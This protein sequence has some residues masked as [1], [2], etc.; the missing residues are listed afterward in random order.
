M[1]AFRDMQDVPSPTQAGMKAR[2]ELDNHADTSCG[3]ANCVPLY[4]TGQVCEVSGFSQDIGKLDNIP[5]ATVCTVWTSPKTGLSYLLILPQVL[6]FGTKLESSLINPNQLRHFGIRV[7]DDP[8]DSARPFGIDME[9]FDEADSILPFL[10]DGTT[11]YFDTRVPTEQE[12]L[13]L[14]RIQLTRD[15]PWDP[16][17]VSIASLSLEEEEL[18]R[19]SSLFTTADNDD[20]F[21]FQNS[22]GVTEMEAD[23]VLSQISPVYSEKQFTE[24]LLG[25]VKVGMGDRIDPE[26][27]KRRVN[28]RMMGS[29]TRHSKVTPEELA[30]KWGVG[31]DTARQTLQATTQYGVRK[32]V[33]PLTRRYR[34]D[35]LD[36]HRRRLN[37]RFYADTL[38]SRNQSG[39]QNTCAQVYTNGKFSLVC[40]MG[41]RSE[42]G[43]TLATFFDEVGVFENL[44]HD[45]APEM[46]GKN[47]EFYKLIQKNRVSVHVT[48]PGRHSQNHVAEK[49]IGE[50]KRRWKSIMTTK[51]VP[52]RIWDYALVWNSEIMSRT[53]RGPDKRTGY[54]EVFG[55]T[56]DISEWLDFDFYDKVF[57]W[58]KEHSD[59]TDENRKIGRWLGIA[60]RIGSDLCYWVL[61]Q[62][63][64]VIARTTV[65]HILREELLKP[66]IKERDEIF[67]EEVRRRLDD[68]D[69]VIGEP[70]TDAF[71]LEDYDIEEERQDGPNTPTDEE[72]GD[73]L[74]EPRPEDDD[75]VLDAYIGAEVNMEQPDGEVIRGRVK[76]RARDD[77]GRPIGRPHR[78]PF[79]DSSM[80]EVELSDG[81]TADYMANVIAENM[82]SQVDEEGRQYLLLKEIVDHRKTEEALTK[83]QVSPTNRTTTKGWDFLVEWKDG[84]TDWVPHK[85]LKAANPIELAE[86]V[87]ANRIN[88]EPAFAWWVPHVLRKRERILKKAKSRYWRTDYKFGIKLPHSVEEALEIDRETGTTFWRNGIEKE[89][90]KVKPAFEITDLDVEKVRR[91]EELIGFQEIT[92]HMVFDIKMATFERKARLVAGKT[93][94]PPIGSTYASVVSR[95][96]VRIALLTAALN[97]LDI[98]SCD[99][100]NAC[101]HA[102]CAQRIWTVA[103]P[104]FGPEV[105]GK[106][107]IV[108]KALYGLSSAGR[109]WRQLLATTIETELGFRP[110]RA[111]PDVYIREAVREDGFEYYEMLLVYTD[112]ILAISHAPREIIEQIGQLFELK[113]GSI[114][115]PHHYLGAG[116][117]KFQLKSGEECWYSSADE[118]LKAALDTVKDMLERDGGK[119]SLR[120]RKAPLSTQYRPELDMTPELTPEM[121][122]R[123]QQLVGILRWCVELGRIDICLEVAKLSAY[124]ANP[125]VGHLEAVYGVFG[126]LESHNRS[127]IV[128]DPTKP[129][130]DESVF[131]GNADWMDFYGDVEEELPPTM[132]KPRGNSVTISMFVDAAHAGNVVTRR[133]HT[134]ILIFL[135]KAP[136]W[137]YS[138][139]QN[140]VESSTF[141]SELVSLRIGT[142]QVKALR[143][144]LRMFGIP[145]DGPANVFCDNE[146]VVKNTSI[147]ESTLTKKHNSINYH[148]VREAAAAD[149][150]RVGKEDSRTNLSDGLSKVLDSVKRYDL[151]SKILY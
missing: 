36:L 77:Y 139:R 136:I 104:E 34:V 41:R 12:I 124:N 58:D 109:S 20:E 91:G 149:I 83:E 123:Y 114:G 45:G 37:T 148:A 51:R 6:W 142:E 25:Q 80:Y 23:K 75:I 94:E 1:A 143:Y 54:E 57:Y 147:P 93:T 108:R 112:D 106:V 151:F 26:E 29:T 119:Y 14:P 61:T 43:G 141:S 11:I 19:L 100:S 46:T 7:S 113:A 81:T 89:M 31:L 76:K 84:T 120:K 10:T 133:S 135:N 53:A 69:H 126:Y 121:T 115:E 55:C 71:Y 50:L 101:L 103:G 13:M 127:K 60:H 4:F 138:K 59:M 38:F 111:D 99:V 33:H 16:A 78:N 86:Y 47:T 15:D 74:Q 72:Y 110:T 42:V 44:T 22:R 146:G 144:K 64:N 140:T 68:E 132:P 73:M 3:G 82:Y 85:D 48:E 122:S 128:L 102:D 56:P 17:T 129:K 28:V 49:E 40:P 30:R 70:G 63:G 125:R 98:C 8:T 97:D 88:E 35:H 52:R 5:V 9:E 131:N 92:C 90:R 130:V 79:L 24:A 32:G 117:G 150:I 118:Y 27:E 87:V 65:C 18:R 39:R 96:S 137:W 21:A 116:V 95:E 107:L 67:E 134:G 105:R 62:S 145:I 66:D 2:C